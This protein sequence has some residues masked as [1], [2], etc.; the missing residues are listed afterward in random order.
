MSPVMIACAVEKQRRWN[1]RKEE[2][3]EKDRKYEGIEVMSTPAEMGKKAPAPKSQKAMSMSRAVKVLTPLP[4]GPA[5]AARTT[6]PQATRRATAW[7][8]ALKPSS[9][10]QS[11][12]PAYVPAAGAAARVSAATSN[13]T[14]GEGAPSLSARYGAAHSDKPAAVN[15]S[16]HKVLVRDMVRGFLLTP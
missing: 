1:I 13:A 6:K 5:N 16:K 14:S 8:P 10:L 9:R 12:A 3:D 15:W 11:R 4:I 2:A 7:C